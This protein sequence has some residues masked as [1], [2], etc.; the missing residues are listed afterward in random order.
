M[1]FVFLV[2]FITL[3]STE[4]E[5]DKACDRYDKA[6]QTRGYSVHDVNNVRKNVKWNNK[7]DI[8]IKRQE[9]KKKGKGE[10]RGIAVV[11]EDKPRLRE[12]WAVCTGECMTNSFGNHFSE[13]EIELLPERLLKCVR[14]TEST[15][16]FVKRGKR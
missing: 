3:C 13:A 12:W 16:D 2:R 10:A 15:T 11:I 8:L 9:K 14:T 5:F 7:K 6:L 1:I 4:K